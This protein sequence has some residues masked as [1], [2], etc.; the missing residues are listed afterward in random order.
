MGYVLAQSLSDV[1]KYLGDYSGDWSGHDSEATSLDTRRAKL[2]GISISLKAQT[3]IYI[4]IGHRIGTNLPLGPVIDRMKERMDVGNH[5][6][7]NYNSKY[8]RNIIQVASGWVPRRFCDMLQLV[9][10]ANPD[11]KEKNLKTVSREDIGFDMARFESLFTPEEIKAGMMD[12]STKSPARCVEYACADSDALMRLWP[13]YEPTYR[14]FSFAVAVDTK[15]VDIVR[16][17]EHNGGMLLNREYIDA[18]IEM[19]Q[20]RED[21]LRDIIHRVVG[22]V[23]EIDSPKQLGIALF[24]RLGIPSPGMTSGRNPQHKTDAENM[25]KLAGKFPIVEFVICY[26]KVVKAKS[27]YFTKLVKLDN[28]KQKVRFSFNMISAPTFRFAAPGGDPLRDGF[29]GINIQAVSNGEARDVNAVDLSV[30]GEQ[31]TYVADEEDMLFGDDFAEKPNTPVQEWSRDQ[32]EALPF[33][34]PYTTKEGDGLACIRETCSGCF[35]GC[36]SRGI[37]TTRKE[38]KNVRMMPSVR[39]SFKAPDGFTLVSCDYDRQEL[40]IGANL[41]GETKWINAL[42]KREDLHM[43]SAC[44]AFLMTPEQFMA[45][46]KEEYDAKRGI[47]KILNFAIFYGATAYTVSNKANISRAQGEQ[48]YDRYKKGHPILFSWIAKVH[49]FAEKNGYTTTFFGRRRWLKE[50]YDNP[51]PKIKAFANRSAVNTCIQGTGAEVTRIAMVKVDKALQMGGYSPKDVYL[52]MQIH[53][54]LMYAVRNELVREVTPIIMNAMAFQ[55]KS[56]PVQLSVAP[57]IGKVW[58]RQKEIKTEE[59]LQLW[60]SEAA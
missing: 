43:Q 21:A 19:L 14:E 46:G 34:L 60:V 37:D 29:T 55:V 10:L 39:Q 4:P 58:G 40:V 20:K 26:R 27:T 6:T 44:D 41:S 52:V 7:F 47:G 24:D 18:Q 33:V 12:I 30:K 16:R 56:W 28:L 38:I 32:Y 3:A 1:D 9:Y 22:Y 45:L 23:F 50:F 25:E 48:I 51:D 54:E 15:L 35:A 8:D 5:T 13:K 11:R 42:N 57:K 53:D 31:G 2:V 59:A 17:V 49:L 36:Q